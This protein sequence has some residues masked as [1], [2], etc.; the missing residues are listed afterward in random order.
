MKTKDLRKQLM[1]AIAMTMVA[2]IAL[3]SSTYAW[4]IN[5]T[6]VTA[7][8]VNVTAAASNTLLISQSDGTADDID[9]W[10][11]NIELTT[12]NALAAADDAG[13]APVST[14]GAD[15][16]TT[17]SFFKSSAWDADDE[18]YNAKAFALVTDNAKTTEFFKD[19]FKIKASQACGLYLTKDTAFSGSGTVLDKTLRLALVVTN[20]TG[21]Y[22]GTYFYQIDGEETSFAENSTHTTIIGDDVEGT[23]KAISGTNSSAKID[24]T[25]ED[26]KTGVKVLDTNALAGNDNEQALVLANSAELLYTFA[27]ADDYCNVTTYIW[28]E[29]C[30]YDTVTAN[31]TDFTGLANKITAK[32]GFG[33]GPAPAT[34]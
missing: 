30:D 19:N 6:L 14:V 5:N 2:V 10:R 25:N 11:T 4:F 15:D 7:G 31:V 34:P 16:T 21:E 18:D 32:L 13:L 3:G 23:I 27:G 20:K 29:G 8:P 28:M 1:A 22:Q 9:G 26:N 33:A 24:V 12:E 17:M